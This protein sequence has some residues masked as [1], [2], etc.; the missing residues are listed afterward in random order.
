MIT[1]VLALVPVVPNLDPD[2]ERLA[3][4]AGLEVL[5]LVVMLVLPLVL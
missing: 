5:A 4:V 3:V 2:L 1:Y